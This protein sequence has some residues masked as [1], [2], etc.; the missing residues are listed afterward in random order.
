[1]KQ[2]A[3]SIADLIGNTPLVRLSRLFQTGNI[4]GKIESLNPCFS[5][6]D[7]IAA[8]MLKAA[9]NAGT[10]KA[11]SVVVEPTSGNTG[12][13]VAALCACKGIK[14]VIVMPDSMSVERRKLL[15]YLGASVVL[16]PASEGLAGS[17]AKAKE[18]VQLD[19]R[20]LI[21]QQF[22]NPANPEA[23]YIGTGREIWDDT[24]GKVDIVVAGVGTGG[25]ISGIGRFMKEKRQSIKIV[26]VEPLDSAVLSSQPPGVH[27]IQGIGPGFEPKVFDRGVVDEIIPVSE[28]DSA[29]FAHLAARKEGILTGISG[30][31]ALAATSILVNK[32]ENKDKMIVT[33]L[34]DLADR[35][36]STWLFSEYDE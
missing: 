31:A 21:L 10:L 1:M 34:P 3:N 13:A 29:S 33:L 15:S 17:V 18:L 36:I 27:R 24:E 30:G 9:E 7:R 19:K 20:F 22:D 12:I 11:D 28:K 23:H 5:V 8:S 35:Y 16:T 14:A 25:T 26:A 32:I 4:L 2:I 6:K